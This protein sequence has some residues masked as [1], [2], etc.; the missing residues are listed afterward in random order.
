VPCIVLAALMLAL[1]HPGPTIPPGSKPS[2]PPA[3][4][5]PNQTPG[6]LP[7]GTALVTRIPATLNARV[8]AAHSRGPPHRTRGGALPPGDCRCCCLRPPPAWRG[9]F[10]RRGRNRRRGQAPCS[11]LRVDVEIIVPGKALCKQNQQKIIHLLASNPPGFAGKKN[12]GAY[13]KSLEQPVC[14]MFF[15]L[16]SLKPLKTIASV[17]CAVCVACLGVAGS[18]F[19]CLYRRYH[20]L[21][22]CA[23]GIL[24]HMPKNA[25]GVRV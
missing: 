4:N 17:E 24:P 23:G 16:C 14:C 9:V 20:D 25:G 18:G 1:D 3:L 5:C 10:Y 8:H 13:K 7:G 11:L 6:L 2:A 21:R 19:T 15:I 12:L 22:I